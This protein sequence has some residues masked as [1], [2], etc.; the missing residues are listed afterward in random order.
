MAEDMSGWQPRPRPARVITHG[1]FVDLVPLN[2]NEH[3]QALFEAS[4]VADAGTRF[5]W[6]PEVPPTTLNE[7]RVWMEKSVASE[8]PLFFAVIDKASGKVAGRQTLM[9]IDADNGVVEIGNIYWGPMIAR[10]R[11]ATE[12]LYLAAQYVFDELGYRRFEWKCNND[13]VPSKKAALRFGFEHEGIFRQHLIVKGLS[14]DTAWFSILDKDW[15]ALRESFEAWLQPDNFDA[16][17]VQKKRLQD[18]R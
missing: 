4:S 11:G 12:A 6:L 8:D 13:N 14:R 2:M 1:R 16:E 3:A 9:R 7:F 10:Q 18:C 5:T 17:G 15:P